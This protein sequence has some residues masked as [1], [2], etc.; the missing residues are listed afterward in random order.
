MSLVSVNYVMTRERLCEGFAGL[1]L[2]LIIILYHYLVCK[3]YL[4]IKHSIV[5]RRFRYVIRDCKPCPEITN[6][7]NPYTYSFL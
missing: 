2:L 6:H 4:N 3:S 5:L 1:L 7:T